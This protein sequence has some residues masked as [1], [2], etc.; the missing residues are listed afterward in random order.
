[1]SRRRE[2]EDLTETEEDGEV[3]LQI[4]QRKMKPMN[5]TILAIASLFLLQ[6]VFSQ[7]Q[8]TVSGALERAMKNSY[9]LI[10]SRADTP[11]DVS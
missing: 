8:L 10:I 1:M 6:P 4:N 5:R 7:E 9:G 3:L 11:G 2:R